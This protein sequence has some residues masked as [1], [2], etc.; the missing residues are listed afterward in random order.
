VLTVAFL[1]VNLP[2]TEPLLPRMSL[3]SRSG[4]RAGPAA[5]CGVEFA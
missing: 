3:G 1:I 5:R 4:D 2:L